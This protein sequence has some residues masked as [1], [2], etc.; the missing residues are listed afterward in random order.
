MNVENHDLLIDFFL[1]KIENVDWISTPTNISR[2]LFYCK[3]FNIKNF[4][5]YFENLASNSCFDVTAIE[6]FQKKY[7]EFIE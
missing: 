2:I 3:Y 6:Y 5:R 4:Y 7:L 1:N